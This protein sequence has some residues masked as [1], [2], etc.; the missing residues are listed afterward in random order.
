MSVYDEK[1]KALLARMTVDEKVGQL[2]QCGP[3]LVG[4]FEVGFE[5]LLDMMFDGR[6]KLDSPLMR[7]LSNVADLI[8]LNL[9][10]LICCVPI[11]TIGPSTTESASA[12]S[13]WSSPEGCFPCPGNGKIPLSAGCPWAAT[14]PCATG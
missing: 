8:A 3:S 9:I 2:Q 1:V 11:V 14:A 10:W 4:A 13:W 5:E 7:F 6:I 12:R